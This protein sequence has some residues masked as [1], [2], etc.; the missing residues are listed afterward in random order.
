MD[1]GFCPDWC[2]LLFNQYLVRAPG[3]NPD[4]VCVPL[5]TLDHPEAVSLDFHY[6]METQ[7]PWVHFDDDLPRIRCDEDPGLAAAF[8]AAEADEGKST[9]GRC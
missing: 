6:G 9:I 8:A 3:F 2:S 4:V 5:G 1:K 7:L